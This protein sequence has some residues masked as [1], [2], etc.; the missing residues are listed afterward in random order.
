MTPAD[1]QAVQDRARAA[2]ELVV[3]FVSAQHPAHPAKAVA[4]A[5]VADPTG[6]SGIM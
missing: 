4:W 6:G 2:G 3:W 5:M 1:A